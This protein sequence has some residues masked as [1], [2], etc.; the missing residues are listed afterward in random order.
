MERAET[1]PSSLGHNGGPTSTVVGAGARATVAQE[2]VVATA[3][4]E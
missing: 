1:I 3:R 2:R 4:R